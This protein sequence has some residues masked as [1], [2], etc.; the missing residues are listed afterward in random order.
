M[1][2]R[3][4]AE[5][6]LLE[7]EKTKG[8]RKPL[9]VIFEILMYIVLIYACVFFIPN[10][11]IQ[12]TIVEGPSMLNTLHNNDSLLVDKFYFKLS[13][14]NRFDIIVF[15]PH[16][17]ESEEYYVKRIIGLPGETVQ[18]KGSDIY[19]NGEVLKENYGKDPIT[20]DGLAE[21]PITLGEDQYFVLGDNREVSLDSRYEDVGLVERKNIGG[22]AIIRIW[23][24]NRFGLIN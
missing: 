5:E 6:D 15:Y 24:L 8:K 9:S 13:G 4:E 11:V 20:Y 3:L 7:Q 23:P 10:Y 12:R 14:L 1:K 17:K 22:R 19:I 16:G 21:D 18:L 2:D